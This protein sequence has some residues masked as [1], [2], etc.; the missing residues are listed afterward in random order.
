MAGLPGLYPPQR[1]ECPQRVPAQD[2]GELTW[3]VEP[4]VRSV[5]R[6]RGLSGEGIYYGELAS[7]VGLHWHSGGFFAVL[8]AV[9]VEEVTAGGPMVTALVMNR[10]AAMPGERFFVLAE[11]LGRT[12]TDVREF[13]EEERRAAIAWIRA[14]PER[15]GITEA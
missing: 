3:K 5:I 15:A 8:D 11:R 2:G 9:S 14:H 7:E 6:Q 1:T 10:R 12:V 13:V 4:R